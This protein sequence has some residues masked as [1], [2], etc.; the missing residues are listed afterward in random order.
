MAL[1][2]G[3][4]LVVFLGIYWSVV[5]AGF[6]APCIAYFSSSNEGRTLGIILGG[7]A[8]IGGVIVVALLWTAV[9]HTTGSFLPLLGSVLSGLGGVTIGFRRLGPK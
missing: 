3:L 2:S 8:V 4:W 6:I 7:I 1:G 5:V 9:N